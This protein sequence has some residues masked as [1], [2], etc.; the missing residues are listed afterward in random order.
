VPDPA[1]PLRIGDLVEVLKT[2]EIRR[3]REISDGTPTLYR[4]CVLEPA[5]HP[6]SSWQEPHLLL[7]PCEWFL[8]EELQLL[9]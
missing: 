2:G 6:V 5:L 1:R 9:S 3:A 4:A 8:A 7:D